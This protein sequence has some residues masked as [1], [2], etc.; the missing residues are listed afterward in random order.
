MVLNLSLN[1]IEIHCYPL[2]SDS[3]PLKESAVLEEKYDTLN[4]ARSILSEWMRTKGDL[5][6]RVEDAALCRAK[7]KCP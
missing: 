3:P 7:A 5:E 1:Q 6:V 2:F 4:E